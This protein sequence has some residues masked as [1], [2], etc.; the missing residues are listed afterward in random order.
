MRAVERVAVGRPAENR[1]VARRGRGALGVAFRGRVELDMIAELVA[2]R[3]AVGVVVVLGAGLVRVG[4]VEG[5]ALVEVGVAVPHGVAAQPVGGIGVLRAGV[6]VGK[7]VAV[8]E[9]RDAVDEVADGAAAGERLRRGDRGRARDA[10]EHVLV[11]G[12]IGERLRVRGVEIPRAHHMVAE[13]GGAQVDPAGRVGNLHHAGIGRRRLHALR[14][15]PGG[16]GGAGVPGGVGLVD[17][18]VFGGRRDQPRSEAGIGGSGG[19]R[20]SAGGH[21]QREDERKRGRGF[22]GAG[23]GPPPT[24]AQRG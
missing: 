8:V 11:G 12:E 2:E 24:L 16:D 6:G 23:Q 7:G 15:V 17:A 13:A 5:H 9:E 19:L 3:G 4:G 10:V 22:H 18:R 21:G 1:R 14:A 20:E